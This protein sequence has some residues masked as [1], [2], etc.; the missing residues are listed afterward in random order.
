MS[1]VKFFLI[2]LTKSVVFYSVSGEEK[3]T[4]ALQEL[5]EQI[6]VSSEKVTEA[7]L[8]AI[9]TTGAPKPVTPCPPSGSSV[10]LVTLLDGSCVT[11]NGGDWN[12]VCGD[13][14]DNNKQI[15]VQELSLKTIVTA[16]A[17][18]TREA[19][20]TSSEKTRDAVTDAI[21]LSFFGKLPVPS[22]P[23]K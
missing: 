9:G 16:N 8:Q 12:K 17:E 3:T 13:V 15:I 14:Y 10:N 6:I 21:G 5:R 4:A 23:A 2:F 11:S 1:K 22:P 20:S 7:V 18:T 19:I